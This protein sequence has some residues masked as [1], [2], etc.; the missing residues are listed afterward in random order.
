[1]GDASGLDNVA[2]QVE[3]GKIEAQETPF[4]FRE[5]RLRKTHIATSNSWV[6]AS[7]TMK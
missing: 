7:Q 4:L 3:I 5:G 2:E 1:M 6:Q